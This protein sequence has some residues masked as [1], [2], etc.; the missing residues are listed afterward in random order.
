MKAG[1]D[2]PMIAAEV[3]VVF[4]CACEMFILELTH[5]GWAHAKENKRWT[6]QKNDI[7]TV[8]TRT[9]IFDFLMDIVLRE[10]G[11]DEAVPRVI[12]GGPVDPLYY[13]VL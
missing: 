9:D 11:R 1:E 12:L 5:R 10:E 7:A 6:L 4:A 3:L 2:V 8:I 13:Y